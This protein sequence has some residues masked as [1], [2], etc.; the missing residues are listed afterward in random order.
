MAC[1]Q[2]EQDRMKNKN[3]IKLLEDIQI[4]GIQP[5]INVITLWSNE[6]DGEESHQMIELISRDGHY[7]QIGLENRR[8]HSSSSEESMAMER[9]N[10][11]KRARPQHLLDENDEAGNCVCHIFFKFEQY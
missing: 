1:I 4:T 10:P 7:T 11:R 6:L 9:R 5:A 3:F 8:T 2:F